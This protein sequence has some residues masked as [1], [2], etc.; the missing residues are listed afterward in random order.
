MTVRTAYLAN[1]YDTDFSSASA[2]LGRVLA[3]L[4]GN[5]QAALV[6][7]NNLKFRVKIWGEDDHG[8]TLD[9]YVIPRLASG[10]LFANESDLSTLGVV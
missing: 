5:Y 2:M 6:T 3:L 10:N 4:P 8:W 1:D 9:G 7:A